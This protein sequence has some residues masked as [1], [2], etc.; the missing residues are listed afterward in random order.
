[1]KECKPVKVETFIACIMV[2]AMVLG[3]SCTRD[4]NPVD[5]TV[6]IEAA[7]G[8]AALSPGD[9]EKIKDRIPAGFYSTKTHRKYHEN[10]YY[11]N[12]SFSHFFTI[13]RF[14]PK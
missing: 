6:Q 3:A 4:P 10:N 2:F 5:G 11:S 8:V 14:I 13:L 1:M 9:M 12:S 7:T